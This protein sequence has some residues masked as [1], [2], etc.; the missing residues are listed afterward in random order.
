MNKLWY[1]NGLFSCLKNLNLVFFIRMIIPSRWV[2]MWLL[3]AHF[4]LIGDPPGPI[5]MLSLLKKDSSVP[6]GW[7]AKKNLLPPS[8][9]FGEE[10]PG[11]YRRISL[12]AW[13]HLIDFYGLDGYALAVVW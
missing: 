5:D 11:H 10:R 4:K 13:I 6:G 9:K 3:F 7:R 12:E 2:R 1:V 8:S